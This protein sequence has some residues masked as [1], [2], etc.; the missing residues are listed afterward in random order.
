MICKG[1]FTTF[2]ASIARLLLLVEQPL[3]A[4]EEAPRAWAA[5]A[6]SGQ[7]PLFPLAKKL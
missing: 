2:H 5:P 3:T 4:L 1:L 7:N 6:Q